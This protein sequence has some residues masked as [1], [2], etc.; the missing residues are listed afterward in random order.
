MSLPAQIDE[1][2]PAMVRAAAHTLEGAVSSAELLE[3]REQASLAY[4]AARRA[5]RLAC[6]TKAHDDLQN[7]IRRV[8]GEALAIEARAKIRLADEYDAAQE[9]GEVVGRSGGGDNT[10]PE[11]NAATA[12]DLGLSRKTIHEARHLRDGERETPGIVS[13]VIQREIEE[14]RAPTRAAVKRA[15]G[16]PPQTSAEQSNKQ[17]Y[18]IVQAWDAAGPAAQRRFREYLAAQEAA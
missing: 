11:R 14:G 17:F 7:R 16:K 12:A 6:A 13:D 8:Q 5:H 18:R 15:V 3:A 10:V 9:R 4:D 2:L 1:T